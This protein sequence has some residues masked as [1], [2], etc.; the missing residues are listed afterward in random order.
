MLCVSY[1]KESYGTKRLQT[2][3]FDVAKMRGKL[4]PPVWKLLEQEYFQGGSRPRYAK[5]A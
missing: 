2:A 1:L 4:C 5:A 3:A